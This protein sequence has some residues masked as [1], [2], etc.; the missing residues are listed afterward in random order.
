M[1]PKLKIEVERYDEKR[2]RYKCNVFVDGKKRYYDLPKTIYKLLKKFE[3]SDNS[4]YAKCKKCGREMKLQ[5]TICSFPTFD[6][7]VKQHFA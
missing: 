3:L 1:Y 5:C 7:T 4:D 6:N 2:S